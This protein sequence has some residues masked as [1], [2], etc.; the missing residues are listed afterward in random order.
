MRQ[1]IGKS[2]TFKAQVNIAF[3]LIFHRY[4]QN[5][6][7]EDKQHSCV[8]VEVNQWSIICVVDTFQCPRLKCYNHPFH[9][10]ISNLHD[11]ASR[12]SMEH[13]TWYIKIFQCVQIFFKK[14]FILVTHIY[15]NI[16]LT[17]NSFF[18]FAPNGH[19]VHY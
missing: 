8:K 1:N 11:N 6:T 2:K 7:L 17:F 4:G 10:G 3:C 18:F 12:A 19:A 9:G 16:F 15:F 14:T 5:K 13:I